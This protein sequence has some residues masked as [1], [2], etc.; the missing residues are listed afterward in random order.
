MRH[1]AH[2][3]V[4]A[5]FVILVR[6][7]RGEGRLEHAQPLRRALETHPEVGPVDG[8]ARRS[9]GGAD[10]LVAHGGDRLVAPL[11]ETVD[12][13]PHLVDVG[14]AVEVLAPF[15]DRRPPVG[16]GVAGLETVDAHAVAVTRQAMLDEAEPPAAVALAV[17]T[18]EGREI[19]CRDGLGHGCADLDGVFA[20]VEE[21]PARAVDLPHQEPAAEHHD[22]A[23]DQQP[24]QPPDDARRRSVGRFSLLAHRFL[25][26][27]PRPGGEPSLSARP[28]ARPRS[29]PAGF[30]LSSS[31]AVAAVG[32][33]PSRRG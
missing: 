21:L 18:F 30:C 11:V 22:K 29:S 27:P 14:E 15:V 13:H 8:R 25:V 19:A 26:M 33:T 1:V 10:E 7:R 31:V 16:H 23:R 9:H 4:A 6:R 32:S 5:E 24:D 28:P 3:P 17:V 20:G 2:D 12:E